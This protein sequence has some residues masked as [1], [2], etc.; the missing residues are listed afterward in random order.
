MRDPGGAWVCRSPGRAR[1]NPPRPRTRCSTPTAS[2]ARNSR[3]ARQPR[4]PPRRGPRRRRRPSRASRVPAAARISSRRRSRAPP[5]APAHA[6]GAAMWL[7][8]LPLA[9][10]ALYGPAPPSLRGRRHSQTPPALPGPFLDAVASRHFRGRGRAPKPV[11]CFWPWARVC[12]LSGRPVPWLWGLQLGGTFVLPRKPKVGPG[13][14][15]V[16]ACGELRD[17][18]IDV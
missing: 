16:A 12:T 8:G 6:A 11:F 15:G 13:T 4:R 17:S 14:S 10:P 3:T 1:G 5:S 18:G 2:H 7:I 9:R